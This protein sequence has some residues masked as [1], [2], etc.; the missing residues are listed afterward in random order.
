MTLLRRAPRE[1]Y[2]VYDAHEFLEATSQTLPRRLPSAEL[3]RV[4]RAGGS[5]VSGA[6]RLQQVAGMVL[7]VGALGAV[8]ALNDRSGLSS[9]RRVRRGLGESLRVSLAQ[10][11][12]G[13]RGATIAKGR[14]EPVGQPSTGRGDDRTGP[15]AAGAPQ[16]RQHSQRWRGPA[17][18]GSLSTAQLPRGERVL[19]A[20]K[21]PGTARALSA[22]ATAMASAPAARRGA[23]HPEFG[24]ER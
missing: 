3:R 8:A 20:P 10:L 18:P 11:G 14:R 19:E 12:L 13:V 2:R 16:M 6:R 23:P 5:S 24:F 21:R 15:S 7:L 4:A 9:P 1:V 22:R 17:R